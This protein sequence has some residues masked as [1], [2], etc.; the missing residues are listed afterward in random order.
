VKQVDTVHRVMN[1]PTRHDSLHTQRDIR[2]LCILS[3]NKYHTN[4]LSYL[5]FKH[6]I[7]NMQGLRN[8]AHNLAHPVT[9]V[10]TTSSV[11]GV[12]GTQSGIQSGTGTFNEP[13]LSIQSGVV[14]STAYPGVGPT[15]VSSGIPTGSSGFSGGSGYQTGYQSGGLG[16]TGG[17]GSGGLGSGV[18]SGGLGSGLGSGGL[19]SGGIGSGGMIGSSGVT[20]GG[21]GS[22]GMVGSGGLGG[23]GGVSQQKSSSY[24]ADSSSKQSEFQ[25]SSYRT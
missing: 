13:G 25:S 16:Q 22:G 11:G 9:G 8:A 20:S 24:S 3:N 18:Q 15:G 21:I 14:E 1:V 4:N 6:S 12:G 23:T 5:C 19:G 7:S 10:P 17:L 2:V